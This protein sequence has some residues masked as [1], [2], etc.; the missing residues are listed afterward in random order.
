MSITTAELINATE[1]SHPALPMTTTT[2]VGP[3]VAVGDTELRGF[4]G[5]AFSQL[6]RVESIETASY[7]PFPG[8]KPCTSY[9]ATLR[10]VVRA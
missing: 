8:R 5:G 9:T 7:V 4:Y 10:A 1:T 2:T 3:D 6:Y